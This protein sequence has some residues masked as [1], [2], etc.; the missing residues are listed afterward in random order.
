M[1]PFLT[2]GKRFLHWRLPGQDTNGFPSVKTRIPRHP[3]HWLTVIVLLALLGLYLGIWITNHTQ[4]LFNPD[5]QNDDA[6]TALFP[7]HRYG[8]E[9]ALADDP[10]ANSMMM[11]M[12]PL[13]RLLYVLAVP[14][15]GLYYASKLIQALCFLIIFYSGYLLLRSPRGLAPSALLIFFMFHTSFMID[16]IAGGLPRAFAFPLF[17]LWMA[18]VLVNNHRTRIAAALLS[19]L[20]YPSAMLLILAAEGIYCLTDIDAPLTFR[21]IGQQLLR[22]TCI[23]AACFI[24]ILPV[25]LK[26]Q[27]RMHTLEE[28]KNEPAFTTRLEVLPF[29]DAAGHAVKML[30]LP[31]LEPV[32]NSPLPAFHKAYRELGSTSGLLFI[33]LLAMIPLLRL[34]PA[35]KLPLAFLLGSIFIYSIARVFA[36]HLYSPERG[37]TFGMPMASVM[38]AVCSVG[39]IGID[40]T[41]W[42]TTA[43]RNL[44]AIICICS[45]WVFA[46]DGIIPNRGMTIARAPNE[47]LY[48]FAKGLPVNV[49]FAAH[50]YDADDLP[51][52]AGRAATDGFETMQ[53]WNI[54][55]WRGTVRRLQDVLR[56]LYATD[57][58]ELL[59]ICNNYDITHILIRKSRYEAD[60]I[61][62]AAVIEPIGAYINRLLAGKQVKDF[63]LA[64][65]DGRA[66]IFENEKFRVLEVALMEKAMEEI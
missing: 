14:V 66:V 21:Q 32:G 43:M 23:V 27:G 54:E 1:N 34:A 2:T 40:R 58:K 46:G 51:Y 62:Q 55:I 15:F 42:R 20:S 60:F 48:E 33:A 37:L 19:A 63:V 47:D 44:A 5:F 45:V 61:K 53:P 31:F 9:G 41:G 56:M 35:P 26:T 28:A 7:F 18:G 25:T 13:C 4:L 3:L 50:P 17:A 36:F 24:L 30:L 11:F 59:G 16:R 29:P 6:R 57:P 52:W 64:K 65:P 10:I 12:T 8:P 49:R 39:L 38:L 22:Y